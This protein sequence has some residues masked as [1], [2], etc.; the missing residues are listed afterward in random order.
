MTKLDNKRKQHQQISKQ[1]NKRETTTT[2]LT[3]TEKVGNPGMTRIVTDWT[4]STTLPDK[5]L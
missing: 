4:G 2:L 5:L 1:N 3:K